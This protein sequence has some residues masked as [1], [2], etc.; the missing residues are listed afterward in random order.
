MELFIR[1][2][3]NQPFEHPILADN[4]KQAFPEV[5][6]N[7]LPEWVA[8][9][10]R[11]AQPSVG[12]YEVYEGVTYEKVGDVYKDV[13]HVRPMTVEEK[14]N[15]QQSVKDKF[16]SEKYASNFSSWI[17]N[18]DICFFEPPIPRPPNDDEKSKLFIDHFWSGSDNNWKDSPP[19][20]QDGKIYEFNYFTWTWDEVI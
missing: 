16:N 2:K 6:V 20:P 9:F 1:I 19:H 5:D 13:H 7:N 11:V 4:F 15:Y 18:E 12:L 3:D 14:T 17:F 8:K 10:E